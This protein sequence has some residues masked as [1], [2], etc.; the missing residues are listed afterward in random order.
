MISPRHN[1]DGLHPSSGNLTF[2]AGSRILVSIS[3]SASIFAASVVVVLRQSNVRENFEKDE[4]TKDLGVQLQV[5]RLERPVWKPKD[6]DVIENFS[7]A[8]NAISP[9]SSK[10]FLAALSVINRVFFLPRKIANSLHTRF[11]KV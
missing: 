3:S 10:L 7:P 9:I 2:I 6:K 1:C 11:L 8:L 4:I 5:A